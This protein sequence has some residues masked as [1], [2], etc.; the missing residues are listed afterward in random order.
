MLKNKE[1]TELTN[2]LKNLTA[3]KDT[4]YSLWKTTK[5]VCSATLTIPPIKL[6]NGDW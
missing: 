2:R 6:D 1:D 4:N 5:Q 3:T